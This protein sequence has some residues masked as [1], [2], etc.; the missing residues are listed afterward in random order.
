MG[1][2]TA[3]PIRAGAVELFMAQCCSAAETRRGSRAARRG[4]AGMTNRVQLSAAVFF[5]GLCMVERARR[6]QRPL[7]PRTSSRHR[8]PGARRVSAFQSVGDP[9]RPRRRCD[10]RSQQHRNI[11][12]VS[13][14][15]NVHGSAPLHPPSS[16]E[17]GTWR[18]VTAGRSSSSTPCYHPPSEIFSTAPASSEHPS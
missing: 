18:N 17:N 13:S 9:F 15:F 5:D 10:G 7:G 12:T 3:R 14:P 16:L 4:E 11:P 2:G 8:S 1:G 6:P